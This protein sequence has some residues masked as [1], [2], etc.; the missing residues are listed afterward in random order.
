MLRSRPHLGQITFHSRDSRSMSPAR[1]GIS[2]CSQRWIQLVESVI[3][4]DSA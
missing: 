4:R 2:R 3:G 1:P